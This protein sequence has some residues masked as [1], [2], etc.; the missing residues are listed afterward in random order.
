MSKMFHI[1]FRIVPETPDETE[2]GEIEYAPKALRVQ[3]P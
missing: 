2:T 3:L 1:P